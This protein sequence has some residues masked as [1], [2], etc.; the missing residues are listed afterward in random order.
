MHIYRNKEEGM[1]DW[2]EWFYPY[3]P[4]FF[5]DYNGRD[6]I[7]PDSD[8]TIFLIG[9]CLFAFLC[10]LF[11]TTESET[12]QEVWFGLK[13][14]GGSGIAS[15]LLFLLGA[16]MIFKAL[17]YVC[18]AVLIVAVCAIVVRTLI[19]IIRMEWRKLPPGTSDSSTN[20]EPSTQ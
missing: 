7:R 20:S 16:T 2:L 8:I 9:L 10:S 18:A 19:Y 12:Q 14:A 11:L 4:Y 13:I 15:I 3:V 5:N 6:Y 17:L 1:L